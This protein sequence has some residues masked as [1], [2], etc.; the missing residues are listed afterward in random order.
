MRRGNYARVHELCEKA[1]AVNAYDP[2]ANYVDGYA[3]FVEG[4]QVTA[5]DR[6][7]IASQQPQYRAPALA[8]IARGYLREG[9][10]KA[11]A[12]AARK[13]L[14]ANDTNLDALLAVAVA[15]RGEDAS[16]RQK[17]LKNVLSRVPLYHPFRYELYRAGG[18]KDF[19]GFI[20]C[21]LPSWTCTE[22]GCW[23]AET[24]CTD[25]ARRFF[26]LA[27]DDLMAKIWLGDLE[28]AKKLKVSGVFP[29]RRETLA[30][31]ECV[32]A[33][34]GHWKFRY[35]LAA[36][37]A[38]F[39]FDEEAEALLES[40]GDEPDEAVF[41]QYRA[42]RRKGDAAIADLICAKGIEDSWRIGRHLAEIYEKKNDFTKVL[43]VTTEYLKTW[44]DRDPLRLA[45]A[46]AL[47][48]L[49]RYR[50]CMAYLET[51][52]LLP[53]EYG[54]N[55]ANIWH[56]CQ[57]AL[58]LKRTW[59]E[60][61]GKGEP[62]PAEKMEIPYGS[63]PQQ[64]G[65]LYLPVKVSSETPVVLNIHGGGWTSLS[66]RDAAGISAFLVE[67]GCAVYSIDYRLAS[68][69]TPWPACGNDCLKAADFILRGGFS[70]QGLKPRRIW[71]IGASAGGHLALWTGLNL[72]ADKVA[73]IISISGVAD[74]IPDV[75]A[76]PKRYAKLFGGKKPD[77]SD[78]DSMNVMKLV[79]K[80]G[81]R[82]LLTHAQ[83]DTVVPV[84]S[85]ANFFNLYKDFGNDDVTFFRYSA[86]DEANTGGHAIWR[87]NFPVRKRLLKCIEDR[88]SAFLRGERC[89]NRQ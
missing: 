87:R 49:K 38:Y 73:G 34:D 32:V 16:T 50:E 63:S 25:D 46:N 88:I 42:T 33:K 17:F 10:S 75:N 3:Y 28:G 76:N 15:M 72:G 11:A 54:G 69:E 53:S 83:E 86:K 36:L 84:E 51:V 20:K 1:L 21:E 2:L 12:D 27:G 9:D 74:P 18:V 23:Y 24:G 29:F 43:E 64:T 5:R 35:L 47:L 56:E 14:K 68:S 48:K 26:E 19:T 77:A 65:D 6:L 79:S 55:A 67:K 37:K 78:L 22:L 89:A 4:D 59:P 30:K 66:R 71:L 52:T 13:A 45:H 8:L 7:G 41:Y 57:D 31:L 39:G 85:S 60:N 62:Y 70:A 40:C 80:N 44:P 81:P 58:G 61:L 82:I